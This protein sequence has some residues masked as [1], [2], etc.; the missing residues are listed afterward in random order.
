MNVFKL[1]WSNRVAPLH[2]VR[3][4][5]GNFLADVSRSN[6]T[7]SLAIIQDDPLSGKSTQLKPSLLADIRHEFAHLFGMAPSM[8]LGTAIALALSPD[9]VLVSKEDLK[10]MK[11]QNFATGSGHILIPFIIGI[12]AGWGMD[13]RILLQTFLVGI[14]DHFGHTERGTSMYKV[15]L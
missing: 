5:P 4:T 13:T 3:E 1:H 11:Y 15:L 6:S 2:P 10:K 7:S 14:R 8:I 12:G 9:E